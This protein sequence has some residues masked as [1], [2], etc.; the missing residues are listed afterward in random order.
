LLPIWDG[1]GRG[2]L[3]GHIF[4]L[5][6]LALPLNL[7]NSNLVDR[8]NIITS[9]TLDCTLNHPNILK[10]CKNQLKKP[11]GSHSVN[12]LDNEVVRHEPHTNISPW[13]LQKT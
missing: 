8:S 7:P 12:H 1:I 10:L 9:P 11:C 2:K 5:R 4:R 6:Q 3:R 13:T